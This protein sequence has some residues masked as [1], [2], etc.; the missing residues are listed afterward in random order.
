M[1]QVCTYF[2]ISQFYLSIL[3]CI[4]NRNRDFTLKEIMDNLIY[5]VN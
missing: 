3:S 1:F 2:N 5:T 4:Y